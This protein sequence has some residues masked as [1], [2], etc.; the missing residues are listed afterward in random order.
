MDIFYKSSDSDRI[1]DLSLID[2]I[3]KNHRET[4]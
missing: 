1:K 4:E 2:N 3:T